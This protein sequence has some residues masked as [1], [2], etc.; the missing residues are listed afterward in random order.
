VDD[1]IAKG[2]VQT[3]MELVGRE[4]LLQLHELLDRSD[5][6]R[7]ALAAATS[8]SDRLLDELLGGIDRFAD[9]LD[10]R[11]DLFA[12]AN[13]HRVLRALVDGVADA[14]TDAEADDDA[15]AGD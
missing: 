12:V 4:R 10:L 8:C 2:A 5:V 3:A 1:V 15:H 14:V 9:F 13:G 6:H 7:R 11:V